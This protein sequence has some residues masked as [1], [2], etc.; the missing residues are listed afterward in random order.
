MNMP[1]TN[2]PARPPAA[3][4]S[5]RHQP[6]A[7]MARVLDR[8]PDTLRDGFTSEQLA[9]LDAALDGNQTKRYPVNI[10][11]SLFSRAFVVV[12]AGRE[13][14]SPN[15]RADERKRHPLRSPGNIAFLTVV[16][17]VG[18]VLGNTL[19]WLVIGE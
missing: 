3:G 4:E 12:L 13:Q 2:L 1:V 9:A 14:R 15:R 18:L 8:L 17:I 5:P 6:T 11:I 7:A 16:A 19:R 10:R